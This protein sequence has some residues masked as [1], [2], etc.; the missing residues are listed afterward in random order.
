MIFGDW[1]FINMKWN[2]NLFSSNNN[3]FA[4]NRQNI[5]NKQKIASKHANPGQKITNLNFWQDLEAVNFI[6]IISSEFVF[7]SCTCR[8]VEMSCQCQAE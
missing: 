3:D 5:M 2:Q 6:L 7:V 1:S 4:V 8:K